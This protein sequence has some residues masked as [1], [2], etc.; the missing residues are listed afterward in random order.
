MWLSF[1]IYFTE[2]R[3]FF[4]LV[5]FIL[6]VYL[7]KISSSVDFVKQLFKNILTKRIFKLE[8]ISIAAIFRH[9]LLVLKTAFVKL[10]QNVL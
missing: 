4:V 3:S 7:V 6:C 5:Y 1:F 8:E 9:N 2:K 10:A